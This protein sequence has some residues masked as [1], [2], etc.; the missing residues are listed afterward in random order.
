MIV[1]KKRISTRLFLKDARDAN[2]TNLTNPPPGTVVDTA[3]T[4]PEW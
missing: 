2:M 4:R 1:V 3:V